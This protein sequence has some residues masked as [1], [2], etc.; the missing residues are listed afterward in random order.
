MEQTH[1]HPLLQAY[2]QLNTLG[3]DQLVSTVFREMSAGQ[4][5]TLIQK[6]RSA[7]NLLI[8]IQSLNCILQGEMD[9]HITTLSQQHVQLTEVAHFPQMITD[10]I[11]H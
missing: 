4:Q 1:I 11:N 8:F 9:Y 7:P 3:A 6:R 2:E 10:I 5:A